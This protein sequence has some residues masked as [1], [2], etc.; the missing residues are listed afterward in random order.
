MTN[1]KMMTLLT[2]MPIS[3][4]VSASCATAR[5]ALPSRVPFTRRSSDSSISKATPRISTVRIRIC[6]LKTLNRIFWSSY[7]CGAS[8]GWRPNSLPARLKAK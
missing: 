7:S 6:A 3:W 2:L 8:T 1:V 4:A 5:M